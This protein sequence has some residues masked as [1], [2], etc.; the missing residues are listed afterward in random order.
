MSEKEVVP[1]AATAPL[2]KVAREPLNLQRATT[3]RRVDALF[4]AMSTDFLLREQFVTDP[5]QVLAE[6]VRG[7]S[8]PPEAAS[9]TNQLLYAV[10]SNRGLLD[11]LRDYSL[12]HR[13]Q[14]PARSKILID[15][16]RALVE[17]G[18]H[19]V[20]I[21]LIRSSL[22]QE[23]VLG[24]FDETFVQILFQDSG[25][26]SD[27]AQ[28]GGQEGGPGHDTGGSDGGTTSSGS[29]Q[30]SGYGLFGSKYVLTLDALNQYSIHLRDLGALDV[31]TL[32]AP[33]RP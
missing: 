12:E 5:A 3:T 15:F 24:F 19:H 29:T 11:W 28:T 8:L 31:A 4:R 32:D 6:Y 21:A 30:K 18:G 1:S 10:M 20:A 17:R 13:G 14:P 27:A 9:V 33:R 7:A 25:I 26:F 2:S 16:S 23:P 22:E